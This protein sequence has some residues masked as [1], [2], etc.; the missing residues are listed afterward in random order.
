MVV[1]PPHDFMTDDPNGDGAKRALRARMRAARIAFAA[2]HGDAAIVVPDAF[3]ARLRRG[4]VVTSYI[5]IAGE[6]D[7]A[8]LA[9]AAL[10]AGCVLALPHVTTRDAPMRF[11]AWDG[12]AALEGGPM[13]LRQPAP[14][15]P[16]V[17]P[18]II[19]TP[20]LAFD[21]AL[22]RL[23][24]GGGFYDRVFARH[25]DAWRVGIAWSVQRVDAVPRAPWDV[26]LH[27]VATEKDWITP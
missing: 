23:G 5:P 10:D 12:G 3:L 24:Q 18:D 13:G 22:G 8:P 27:A 25:P 20:L 26:A 19:L 9:R 14:D 21:A 2:D 17:A 7:P 15:A 16:E 1:P 11:L 6:A 4:L